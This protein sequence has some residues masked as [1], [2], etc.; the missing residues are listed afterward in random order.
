MAKV[1]AK[2]KKR[3][4]LTHM[5]N[6]IKKQYDE[7]QVGFML[8]MYDEYKKAG[9]KE[10]LKNITASV[11]KKATPHRVEFNEWYIKTYGTNYKYKG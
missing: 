9:G 11:R 1:I 4:S 7:G 2:S 8:S 3:M 10:S 6:V 5:K